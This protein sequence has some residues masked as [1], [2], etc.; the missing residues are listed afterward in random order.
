MVPAAFL[1]PEKWLD[2]KLLGT[3][4]LTLLG[5]ARRSGG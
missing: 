3:G 1:A 4:N 5:E 2:L